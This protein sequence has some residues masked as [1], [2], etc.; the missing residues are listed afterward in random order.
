MNNPHIFREL[1]QE[2]S[3]AMISMN[4]HTVAGEVQN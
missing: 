3:A 1:K 4:I 2:I